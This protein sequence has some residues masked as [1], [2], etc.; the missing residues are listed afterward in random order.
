[1]LEVGDYLCIARERNYKVFYEDKYLPFNLNIVGV[2]SASAQVNNYQDSINIYYQS[3]ESWIH[4]CFKATTYPGLPSLLNPP[5]PEG[6]AILKEGQ[7]VDAYKKG[8]HKGKYPALV[9]AG[10]VIVYRDRN[11]DS[12]FNKDIL[13]EREGYFGINIHRAS[14][15]AKF[16]GPDSSG[17]QVIKNAD[18]YKQF[19]Y[20]IDKSLG[21]RNNSFTYTLV[22]I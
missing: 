6:T 18:D 1:M 9:Q 4:K 21:Y 7:Y 8:L 10:P 16:V 5:N 22:E 11:R 19:L 17:C 12:V 2:R 20:Y 14:F 15:G 13:T 3:K